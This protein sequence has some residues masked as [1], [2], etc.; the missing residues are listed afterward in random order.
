MA[1]VLNAAEV[2]LMM[3]LNV[4]MKFQMNPLVRVVV[5]LHVLTIYQYQIVWYRDRDVCFIQTQHAQNL[6]AVMVMEGILTNQVYHNAPAP[7]V[8]IYLVGE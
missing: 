1:L 7:K 8:K 3:V 5:K 2:P 4:A 6:D